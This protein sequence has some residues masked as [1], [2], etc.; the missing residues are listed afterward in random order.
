MSKTELLHMSKL[1]WCVFVLG[2]A[3]KKC[4]NPSQMEGLSDVEIYC[5]FLEITITCRYIVQ[6]CYLAFINLAIRFASLVLLQIPVK[7]F[8]LHV[9][10]AP[11]LVSITLYQNLV[12]SMP[13]S[14]MP[15]VTGC[16]HNHLSHSGAWQCINH[17]RLQHCGKLR[18]PGMRTWCVDESNCDWT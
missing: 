14:C 5:G 17:L 6:P 8:P 3:C 1:L 16:H 9:C 7:M 2:C 10:H 12:I 4:V 11:P 18:R 13:P 15:L